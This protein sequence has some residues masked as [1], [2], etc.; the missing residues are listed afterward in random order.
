M[1][2]ILAFK[3]AILG[4]IVLV[5]AGMASMNNAAAQCFPDITWLAA[6]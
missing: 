2:R 1:F 6:M 5:W 3:T 4:T